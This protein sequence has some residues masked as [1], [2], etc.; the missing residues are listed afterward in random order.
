MHVYCLRPL[1]EWVRVSKGGDYGRGVLLSC[2]LFRQSL[3][4][5]FLLA[6]TKK[7]GV[8][9]ILF[10]WS[11]PFGKIGW[12]KLVGICPAPYKRSRANIMSSRMGIC[13]L[14]SSVGLPIS[15]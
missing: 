8:V 13:Y 6:L 10:T 15:T 3:I 11:D 12:T 7:R 5:S 2:R 1:T 9:V 14:F 4:S